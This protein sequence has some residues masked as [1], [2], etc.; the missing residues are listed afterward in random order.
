[1]AFCKNCGSNMD[2]SA[3]VCSTCG[4][5]VYIQG[6]QADVEPRK[7]TLN[8]GFL[9]WSIVN[10]VLCCM[11]LGIAG[12][13]FTITAQNKPTFEEEQKALKN[14]KIFNLIGTIV[15]A[16]WVIGVI[17][18]AILVPTIFSSMEY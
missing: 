12:L 18:L 13:V 14:A 10:I 17:L 5:P 7:G 1:M 4:T 15:G 3:N 6:Y 2:D 8:T 11:P 16:V 9:I